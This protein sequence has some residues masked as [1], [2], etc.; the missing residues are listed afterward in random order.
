MYSISSM[1]TY[2]CI[3]CVLCDVYSREA[4][5]RG[6]QYRRVQP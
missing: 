1:L 5:A 3:V 6:P 2:S 4:Q